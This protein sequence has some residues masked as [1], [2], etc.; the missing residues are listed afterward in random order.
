MYRGPVLAMHVQADG[1]GRVPDASWQAAAPDLASRDEQPGQ[2]GG[3]DLQQL[4]KLRDELVNGQALTLQ[5][6]WNAVWQ[7]QSIAGSAPLLCGQ[8]LAGC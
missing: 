8:V 4:L 2:G 7:C 5:L 6:P 3:I 1:R